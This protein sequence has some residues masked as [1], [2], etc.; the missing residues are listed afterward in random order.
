NAQDTWPCIVT[1]KEYLMI[2]AN[3]GRAAFGVPKSETS[4]WFRR[5]IA[6]ELG[7]RDRWDYR[8]YPEFPRV[9]ETVSLIGAIH[10]PPN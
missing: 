5:L 7:R 8:T 6:R 10:D 3:D 4:Q 1:S 9:K 2:K